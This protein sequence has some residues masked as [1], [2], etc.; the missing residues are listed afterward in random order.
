MQ[1]KVSTD[2]LLK[3][4]FKTKNLES[5]FQHNEQNMRPREFCTL[6][7]SFCDQRELIPERV[8]FRAQ[9]DRT[10]GHQLFNGTRRPSRDKVLQLAVGMGLTVEETQRLLQAAGKSPLYPRLKR[11]AALVFCLKS[12]YDMMTTQELLS[13][14]GLLLL[15][16]A[17]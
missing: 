17:S 16:E 5:F 4:I 9:I 12:G 2:S 6:L 7:A 8:I 3:R 13:Q 1:D 15:G 14:Y 10:Y 11:D